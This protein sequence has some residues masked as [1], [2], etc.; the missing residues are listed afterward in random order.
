[1]AVTLLDNEQI[2]PGDTFLIEDIG[3]Y[4][5]TRSA[6]FVAFTHRLSTSCRIFI[7]SV[8]DGTEVPFISF[9]GEGPL[10]VRGISFHHAPDMLLEAGSGCTDTDAV[11][12]LFVAK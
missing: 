5:V 8:N 4:I 10:R 7:S 9:N 1:M 12:K 11:L 2:N 3:N 6:N